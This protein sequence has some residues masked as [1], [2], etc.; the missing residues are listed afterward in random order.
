VGLR[1]ECV[2]LMEGALES[3][4]AG[5]A[6]S[7]L[8]QNLGATATVS[9]AVAAAVAAGPLWPLLFDPQTAGGLLAGWVDPALLLPPA[10]LMRQSKPPWSA[11]PAVLK[12]RQMWG[13]LLL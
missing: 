7:L 3:S 4:K 5:V 13:S 1:A 2:P 6:S 8:P 10:C 9:N 11:Q 12:N